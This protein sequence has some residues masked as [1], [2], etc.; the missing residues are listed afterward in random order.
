MILNSILN[1][2]KIDSSIGPNISS[3]KTIPARNPSYR[4]LPADLHDSLISSLHQQGI[5]KLYDHQKEAYEDIQSGKNIALITGTSSGKTLA[6][7]LPV[8]D[9]ILKNSSS[10][11]LFLY[12]TKALAHDQLTLLEQFPEISVNAYDGDTP[13]HIRKSIRAKSQIIVSNPD[14]LHLGTLPYHLEWGDFFSKLDF[15]VIDEIHTYRGVFGSHVAN[16][17]HRL[18]RITDHYGSMPQFILTSATIGNPLEFARQLIDQEISVI[19]NDTSARGKKFF[20]IYNPPI[21]DKKLG[22][23]ASM[24]QECVRLTSD[25]IYQDFQTILFGRSRRSVEF[26]LSALKDRYPG[27]SDSIVSYRSGYLP[28]RRR[29]IEKGLKN[30]SIRCVTATNALELG[31]DIGG[32]DAAVLAGYPGTISGTLQQAGRSGRSENDSLSILVASSSPLD[33]YLAEHPEYM[34]SSNPEKAFIDPGNLLIV[35][36]HIQCALYELPFTKEMSYGAFSVEQT[37]ELLEAISEL[38]KAYYSQA[39]YYWMAEDY[40]ASSISLRTTTSDQVILQ[41]FRKDKTEFNLGIIDK[42]SA[43]WMVHPGAIYLHEGENYLVT[44]F[45]IQNNLAFLSPASNDYYTEPERQ[46]SFTLINLI[47]SEIIPGGQKYYGD[48]KVTSQVTGYKKINWSRYE[49]LGREELD[50]PTTSLSTQG[51][52]ITLSEESEKLLREKGTWSSSINDYGPN[53]EEIRQKVLHRDKNICQLCGRSSDKSP[54][55]VHH[56]V[57]MRNFIDINQANSLTN[58]VSL[59]PRC[60]QRAESVVRINSGI[61]G[62]G[63]ALHGLAPLL[64]MCDPGDLGIYTDFQSPFGHP[65]P[66]SLLFEYVPAGIGFSRALYEHHE[67]LLNKAWELVS[68]CSCQNGCPSCVGPGGEKG[69]GGKLETLAILNVLNDND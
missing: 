34:F 41:V 6:Y 67:S 20:I 62:L 31:I 49:I 18:K 8:L 2:W 26:M 21:I 54:L 55:H 64:L 47:D 19:T 22:L 33:Q 56:K 45:D 58:L 3:W 1:R 32:L 10:R 43:Y 52:W 69:S 15:V 9:R 40:P 11:A 5:Q 25:L 12:P 16:V 17:F 51:F 4:E 39:K 57:P 42:D 7:I 61:R 24:Q 60:H 66:I 59:C 68:N 14:M 28:S 65:R 38:G 50:L 36:A 63:F 44:D 35:L 46:T 27:N 48:I 53:W 37:Q 29:E 30:G 13:K 23:R